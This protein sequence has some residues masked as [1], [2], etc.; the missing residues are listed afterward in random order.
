MDNEQRDVIKAIS[1]AI[2]LICERD[3]CSRQDAIRAMLVEM[4]PLPPHIDDWLTRMAD[5]TDAEW[6]AA[7]LKGIANRN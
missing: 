2:K 1:T 3:G 7:A 5:S 6:E 4:A